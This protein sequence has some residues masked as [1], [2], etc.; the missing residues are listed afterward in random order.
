[1]A[2]DTE[3]TAD[4]G[5]RPVADSA[6]ASGLADA[7][8]AVL[9]G[10]PRKY[11]RTQLEERSGMDAE[12][13]RQLWRSM[14]FAEVGDEAVVFT[15]ADLA[16]LERVIELRSADLLDDDTLLATTRFIGQS[17]A[18]L[19]SWE[20][21]LSIDQ[22]LA[23]LVPDS[24][25][26][27]GDTIDFADRIVPL[28][29]QT[30][31]YVWRRQLASFLARRIGQL[32]EQDDPSETM[33]VGFADI[34]G[35]TSLSRR[36]TEI[37][38]HRLLGEFERVATFSV[39]SEGGRVVKM[40]GDAVLFAA[41]TSLAGA[42]IALGMLDE[43]AAQETDDSPHPAVKI[44]VAAGPVVNR[45]GDVFGSTVNIASRLT[46]ISR[47]GWVLVDRTMEEEL[48]SNPEFRLVSRRPQ[49]VRGFNRLYSW[50]LMRA[51]PEEPDKQKRSRSR[52]RH[53]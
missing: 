39:G 28:L 18:Q 29:E 23:S 52:E 8:E 44:G 37:E 13:A 14:G 31:A 17:F 9:L 6:A 51:E 2:E 45:L 3:E 33:A 5:G 24:G 38:L 15:D 27:V 42:R 25:V 21:Q 11:T 19:A 50:R 30:H 1:M 40:I 7:I 32:Q 41:D 20:G 12:L 22:V 47:P 34:S 4:G 16:E 43:W 53:R 10:G 26:D 36:L 35:Y 48:R 46:S 49:E